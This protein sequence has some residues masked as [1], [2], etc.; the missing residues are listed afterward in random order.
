[1]SKSLIKSIKNSKIASAVARK[2]GTCSLRKETAWFGIITPQN[3]IRESFSKPNLSYASNNYDKFDKMPG[4][5]MVRRHNN[6]LH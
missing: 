2:Q 6:F 4:P 1:M 5:Y 3:I